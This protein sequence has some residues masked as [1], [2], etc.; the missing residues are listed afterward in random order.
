[1]E[2]I[3]KASVQYNDFKGSSAADE[4]DFGKPAKWLKNNGYIDD[5]YR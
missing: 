1:M 2:K 5:V 3:F 4:A